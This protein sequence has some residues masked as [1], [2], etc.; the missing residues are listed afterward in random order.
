MFV[1]SWHPNIPK[2]V[3]SRF[4][5]RLPQKLSWRVTED[6]HHWPL[7][8]ACMHTCARRPKCTHP[9]G[10]VHIHTYT[11]ITKPTGIKQQ[12]LFLGVKNR[13]EQWKVLKRTD[14]AGFRVNLDLVCV[15]L[16]S[17]RGLCRKMVQ[18]LC[19]AHSN[20]HTRVNI[21]VRSSQG[22]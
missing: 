19:G 8:S 18:V 6:A 15:L 16:E 12:P 1:A 5:E 14:E 21:N 13:P 9:Q 4:T 10:C 17:N 2:Y 11:R 7:A 20:G 22:T 3:S